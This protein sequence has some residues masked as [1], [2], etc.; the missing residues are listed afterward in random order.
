[1]PSQTVRYG[2]RHEHTLDCSIKIPSAFEGSDES[3]CT[4]FVTASLHAPLNHTPQKSYGSVRKVTR[5]WQNKTSACP[6]S[7]IQLV[8][9]EVND[10]SFGECSLPTTANVWKLQQFPDFFSATNTWLFKGPPT[11]RQRSTGINCTILS[12][13]GEDLGNPEQHHW[14]QLAIKKRLHSLISA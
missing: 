7:H 10:R 5:V 12:T 13:G 4:F 14:H 6:D 11:L 3:Y 8:T 1:M 9:S 2:M